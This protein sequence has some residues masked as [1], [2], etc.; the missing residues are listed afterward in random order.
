MPC[1]WPV[2]DDMKN[3]THYPLARAQA[4]Y[5]GDGVACVLADE[6]R[7]RP[8]RARSD[9][10]AV[11]AARSR[12]R[13]RGRAVRPGRRSTTISAPTRATPGTSWSRT[14]EGAVDAGVRRGRAHGQRALHPAATDP[15]GDGAARRAG[16]A[17]A[18][19]RR[20]D[21]VLGH[22]GPPHPEGDGRRSRSA[23]PSTRC[24]SSPRRR[25]RLRLEAQRLRRGAAV[26]GAGPQA[27]H[28]GAL[29]RGRA[30]RTRWR[31]S[32]AAARSR[33]SSS[34]PT[35]TASSPRSASA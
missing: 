24:V 33:T 16:D 13:P 34:P 26:R 8:R 17:A 2:T 7:R 22:P 11:R 12:D 19:R 27:R 21:A 10:R 28:A 25:W 4:C 14:S 1:A 9:R 29:E 23:S 31:R 6:R 3:P 18:V 32:T 30:P 35:P 5:A 15:D 20:D